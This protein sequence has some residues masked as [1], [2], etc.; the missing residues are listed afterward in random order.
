MFRSKGMKA[1]LV[2]LVLLVSGTT[3][4][5]SA[6]AANGPRQDD[7]TVAIYIASDNNLE[8]AWDMYTLDALLALPSAKRVNVVAMVDKLSTD[9]IELMEFSGDTYTVVKTY[10]DMNTGDGA[11]FQF[12]LDTVEELY[13]AENVCVVPWNH[14]G[15]WLGVCSD[16]DY[17]NDIIRM[18]ELSDALV[19]AG[20]EIDVMAFDACLMS[21]VEVAYELSQTGLV[22]Y[23]VASEMSIPFDGFPYDLMFTPLMEDSTATPEMLCDMMLVGWDAYYHYGRKVNLAVTDVT[24]IGNALPIFQAWSEALLVGLETHADGYQTALDSAVGNGY[25]GYGVDLHDFCE[26]LMLNVEDEAIADACE[27]VMGVVEDA[28]VAL[29]TSK[30]LQTMHGL[31]I[32]WVSADYEYLLVDRYIAMVQFVTDTGYDDLQTAWALTFPA[33]A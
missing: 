24:V 13:P 9:T 29:H 30:Y 32:W 3:F 28:V 11:T 8:I 10:D 12:F 22:K 7:W 4:A 23:M 26:Q 31:T 18:N 21:S 25:A 33:D 5:F 6:T 20:L 2:V 16:E 19:G 1:S 15:S 27:A 17:N 14:G